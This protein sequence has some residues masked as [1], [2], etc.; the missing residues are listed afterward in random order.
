MTI[1][2]DL[3]PKF[4]QVFLYDIHLK[5]GATLNLGLFAKDGRLNKHIIQVYQEEGSLFSSYGLIFNNC[6]GDT[7]VIT[8]VV[9]QGPGSTSNQL[10]FALAGEDSQTV[11][12]GI[13]IVEPEAVECQIG[14]ES[15]NL[16]IGAKGRCHAKPETYINADNVV[17]SVTTENNT[18]SAERIDYLESRGITN[19]EARSMIISGFRDQVISLIV[20]DNLREE[21]KEIYTV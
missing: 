14:V 21:L 4:Q 15:S 11:Y 2:N 6:A 17:S 20:R 1:V 12:Q 18:I 19:K 9:H 3:D 5:P 7:E 16:V 8:K 13:A 10:F